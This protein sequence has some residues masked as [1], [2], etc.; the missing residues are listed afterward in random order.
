LISHGQ[1]I[2][3]VELSKDVVRLLFLFLGGSYNKK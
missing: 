1:I 2:I 3:I